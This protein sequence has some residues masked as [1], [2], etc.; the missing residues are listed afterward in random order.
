MYQ[1]RNDPTLRAGLKHVLYMAY[2]YYKT[3]EANPDS[4]PT[5]AEFDDAEDRL[6]ESVFQGF[7]NNGYTIMPVAKDEPVAA[8]A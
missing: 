8:Q 2:L 7:D 3:M 4:I 6:V 1:M 5:L